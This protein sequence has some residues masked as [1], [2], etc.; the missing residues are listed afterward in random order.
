MFCFE[1]IFFAVLSAKA[2]NVLHY[3]SGEEVKVVCVDVFD[4][5]DCTILVVRPANF[6]FKCLCHRLEW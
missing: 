5:L 3:V 6:L 1:Q 2:S 4:R